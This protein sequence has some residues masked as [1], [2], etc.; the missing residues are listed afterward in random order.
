MTMIPENSRVQDYVQKTQHPRIDILRV[1]CDAMWSDEQAVIC[2]TPLSCFTLSCGKQKFWPASSTPCRV[3]PTIRKEKEENK[4]CSVGV[5]LRASRATMADMLVGPLVSLLKEK[6]SSY[7]LDQ[8]KVM[9]GMEEQREILG[10]RLPAILDRRGASRSGVSAW[11]HALKKVSYEA[12]DVFDEFKYEA[13]RREAR[14]KG[15]Y[16]MLSMDVV[17][18]FPDHNRVVFRYRMGKKL[19]SI[20]QA[21][22]VLLKEMK[23]FGFTTQKQEVPPLMMLRQADSIMVDSEK[24]LLSRSRNEEKNKIV[25]IL[26]EQDGNGV[27]PMLIYNDPEVQKHFS[28]LRWCCVSEDFDIVTI[29]HKICQRHEEDREKT[30]QDFRNELSGK[31]YLIVLDDWGKLM[32]CLKQGDKGSAILTT[33]RNVEVA[34]VMTM[35]APE[36]YYLENLGHKYMKEIILSRAFSVQKPK[37]EEL[38]VILNKVVDRC[39]SE[40]IWL[41]VEHQN[42]SVTELPFKP[43]HLQHLR[44]LNMS[45]NWQMEELPQEISLLY[46]LLTMDLSFCSSL[47]RLPND[48]KY[49]RSLRH[50]YTNGCRS[51]QYMPPDL[52]QL[53]SLQTLIYFVVG[54]TSGCSTVCELQNINLG[55]ELY[56]NGLKKMQLKSMQKLPALEVKRSLH[57]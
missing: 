40:S 8:Y 13:L 47:R 53:T 46:N 51:L 16:S 48:L 43:M 36:A 11:L 44:Y 42:F 6:A 5:L 30:L 37:H 15:H 1:D 32:T 17:S 50:L 34:R 49:M 26:L 57:T 3:D 14:R 29:A 24:D 45:D 25:K 27:V 12:I 41:Y 10:R 22:E 21:I 33:T 7:L 20:V 38:D 35:G 2:T 54:A 4:P 18:L 39:G 23:A 55:G 31:R 52:G 19:R 28:F 56:L 9:Q